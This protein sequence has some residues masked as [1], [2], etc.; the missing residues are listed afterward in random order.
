MEKL[1]PPKSAK[2]LCQELGVSFPYFKKVIKERMPE[3]LYKLWYASTTQK[4]Y[5]FSQEV[6]YLKKHIF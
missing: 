6:E 2:Q 4:R 5:Y 1:D 3:P